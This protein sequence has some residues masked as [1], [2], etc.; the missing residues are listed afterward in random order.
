MRLVVLGAGES[1][2]G[3]ALLGKKIGY[4]VFV[5]DKGQIAEKYKNVLSQAEISFEEGAHTESLILNAD[6]VVKSPGI[7]DGVPIIKQLDEKQVEVIDELEL[8]YRQKGD[9]KIVAITGSN[10]KT[11]TATLTHHI[12]KQAGCKVALVGNV[13]KSFAAVVATDPQDVY[14]VEVS[15]FQLDRLITFKPDVAV[16]LN[17][18]PDHLDRYDYELQNYINS[19][20]SITKNQTPNEVFVYCADDEIVAN[21]IKNRLG[22]AKLM[23][24]SLKAFDGEGAYIENEKI[25]ILTNDKIFEMPINDL[26]LKGNHNA[27]NSMASGI[28][29]RVL[30]LRKQVVRESMSDFEN[31]EHRL[32]FVGKV[33]GVTFIN[34]SKA[35]NVNAAWYALESVA[36]PVVWIVGGVDKGNDYTSLKPLVNEKVSAIVCLGKDNAKIKAEFAKEVDTIVEA[37]SAEEAVQYAFQLAEKNGTVLLAPACASFDL[38]QN[39]ED[40]GHQFKNAVRA[41]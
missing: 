12:F 15:S 19:K 17:I 33:H 16:L 26:A 30:E 38:F 1:G 10:G 2:V 21:A 39:Y 4:E 41:L 9:S 34:D 6:M 40:R 24:F 37:M 18:T 28:A 14:V 3:A 31:I 8:A 25:K 23:P 11:T 22:N 36:A 27:Y 13:G 7:P 29:A 20:M 5:S 35:T 32:E